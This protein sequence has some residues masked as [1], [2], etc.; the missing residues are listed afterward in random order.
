[1]ADKQTITSMSKTRTP[2]GEGF[3]SKKIG[4]TVYRVSVH[5]S[6]T[7]SERIEDKILRLA[8]RDTSDSEKMVGQ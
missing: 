5:F 3:I 8:K 1:M 6:G 4:N 7:S 2:E